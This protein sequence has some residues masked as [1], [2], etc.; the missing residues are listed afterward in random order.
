MGQWSGGQDTPSSLHDTAQRVHFF[1][2]T[3][4]QQIMIQ[5]IQVN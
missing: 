5:A 1:G 2:N 4:Q 3:E